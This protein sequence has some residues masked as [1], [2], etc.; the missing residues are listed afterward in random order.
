M[1]VKNSVAH[2]NPY[3]SGQLE[4]L[5]LVTIR[6]RSFVFRRTSTT[7]YLFFG[8]NKSE[9][10]FNLK[11]VFIGP[12]VRAQIIERLTLEKGRRNYYFEKKKIRSKRRKSRY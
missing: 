6:Y 10:V 2:G 1:V 7:K 5:K 4:L 3:H 8:S 12:P 9:C 11:L